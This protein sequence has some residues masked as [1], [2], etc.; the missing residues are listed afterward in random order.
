M[1]VSRAHRDYSVNGCNGRDRECGRCRRQIRD[2]SVF[3]CATRRHSR[4]NRC[5]A[6]QALRRSC[7]ALSAWSFNAYAGVTRRWQASRYRGHGRNVGRV[8]FRQRMMTSARGY[9][10]FTMAIRR[11]VVRY[12]RFKARI[13]RPHRAAIRRVRRSNGRG[14]A[15]HPASSD[16]I[17]PTTASA[18]VSG[19]SYYRR[20][21][22]GS[23]YDSGVKDSSSFGRSICREVS[24]LVGRLLRVVSMVRVI[25]GSIFVWVFYFCFGLF[26]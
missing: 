10:R 26:F 1:T 8:V 14:G 11:Q 5:R 6:F 4:A 19:R 20:I 21:R 25:S 2:H 17:V 18:N 15:S 3:R 22:S 13:S 23:N 16:G 24:G 9:R 7:F 12:A